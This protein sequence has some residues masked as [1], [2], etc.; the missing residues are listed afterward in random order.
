MLK[1][2]EGSPAV[3]ECH[4][5]TGEESF[6]VRVAVRSAADLEAFVGQFMGL[7]RTSSALILSTLI[8]RAA[9]LDSDTV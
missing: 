4:H 1:R 8:R 9:P 6:L 5:L 2:L 7:G 3:L